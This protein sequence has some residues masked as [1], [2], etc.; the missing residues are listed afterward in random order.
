MMISKGIK[1]FFPFIKVKNIFKSKTFEWIWKARYSKIKLYLWC[2]SK[3]FNTSETKD[4]S[5]RVPNSVEL[6]F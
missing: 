1:N 3:R 2:E 6:T 5:Y 4:K